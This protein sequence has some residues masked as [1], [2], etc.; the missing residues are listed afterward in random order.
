MFK[1]FLVENT[2]FEPVTPCLPVA[3]ILNINTDNQ[4]FAFLYICKK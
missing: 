4:Y 2:G 3:N 1:A